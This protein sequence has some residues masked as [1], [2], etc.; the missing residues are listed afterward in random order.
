[1][2]IIVVRSR[3]RKRILNAIG[4]WTTQVLP[5]KYVEH[6]LQCFDVDIIVESVDFW[7]VIVALLISRMNRR[8]RDDCVEIAVVK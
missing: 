2:K 5:V 7:Y 1:M 8:E 6:S 3:T 4:Y